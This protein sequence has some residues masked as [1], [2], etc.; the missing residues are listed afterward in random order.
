MTGMI[1]GLD[2]KGAENEL[3]QVWLVLPVVERKGSH[4][5]KNEGRGRGMLLLL[6]ISQ[7]GTVDA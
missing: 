2:G 1:K 7:C 6:P 5:L 3:W 4:R